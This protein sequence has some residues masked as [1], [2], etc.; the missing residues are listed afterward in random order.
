M[1]ESENFDPEPSYGSGS[2][3]CA[4][5]RGDKGVFSPASVTTAG[6]EHTLTQKF[7]VLGVLN[8]LGASDEEVARHH[9]ARESS[10]NGE[11]ADQ[12]LYYFAASI[13]VDLDSPETG[14]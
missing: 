13:E 2:G 12:A 11:Q 9:L 10:R 6:I 1:S 7:S 8:I 3:T 5:A 14:R 4:S